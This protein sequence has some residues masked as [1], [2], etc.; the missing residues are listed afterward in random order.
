MTTVKQLLQ[1]KGHDLWSITP[2]TSV[3]DALQLM[4]E[5][6]VGALLVLEAGD[7]VGIIS[8]RD[9]ARMTILKENFSM[10]TPVSE[11]MTKKVIT[12]S[13][14]KPIVREAMAKGTERIIPKSQIPKTMIKIIS[15]H[16]GSFLDHFPKRV[17]LESPAIFSKN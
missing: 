2:D 9:Y 1:T 17:V 7:L 13:V 8:E 10:A 4:A 12:T 11:I 3:H 16:H 14:K 15:T 6:N 5:K